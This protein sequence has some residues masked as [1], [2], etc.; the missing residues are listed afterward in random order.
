MW[1]A[2]VRQISSPSTQALLRLANPIKI[3]SDEVIITF[4]QEIFVKQAN[5]DSKKQVIVDAANKLFN[6]S[7]T[8]VTIRLPQSGDAQLPKLQA[9]PSVAT[10]PVK[11]PAPSLAPQA[12]A[13]S[14]VQPVPTA[15]VD[16]EEPEEE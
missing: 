7:N 14:T 1:Q 9:A 2:L 8:I 5:D 13:N 10:A 6:Q 16:M 3:A 15:V 12:K 4:K 11:Q